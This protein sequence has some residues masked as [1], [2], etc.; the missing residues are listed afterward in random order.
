MKPGFDPVENVF[1]LI[2][3]RVSGV[4]VRLLVDEMRIMRSR[5]AQ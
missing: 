5:G 3:A 4:S 1:S 2:L